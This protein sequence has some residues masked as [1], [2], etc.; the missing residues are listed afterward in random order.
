MGIQLFAPKRRAEYEVALRLRF[1]RNILFV[2]AGLSVIYL[3]QGWIG[4]IQPRLFPWDGLGILILASVCYL[5]CRSESPQRVS[6][7]ASWFVAGINILAAFESQFYGI[8]HPIS[9][10]YVLGILLAGL[11]IGGWF[12]GMWTVGGGLFVLL[13]GIVELIGANDV[14]ANPLNS[15]PALSQ[16]V[17][18]WWITFGLT[19]WLVSLFAYRLEE[20]LQLSRA[21]TNALKETVAA[22]NHEK[23]LEAFMRQALT[24]IAERLAVDYGTLFVHDEQDG[25]VSPQMVYQKGEVHSIS[26]FNSEVPLPV[27]APDLPIWHHLLETNTA[28]TIDNPAQDPRILNKE[29]LA[30]QGISTILYIPL[31]VGERLAGF[32][33]LN[34]L[35]KRRFAPAEIDLAVTL[36]QLVTLAMQLAQLA[37]QQE[38]AA[39][40]AERTRMSREL[41]DTLAQG[42]TG[43]LVQLEAAED[44]L[45]FEPEA[46]SSHLMR[47][48][49]LARSGLGEARRSV[50]GL[51]P[52]ILEQQGLPK[53]LENE[54]RKM[55]ADGDMTASYRVLGTPFPLS[56]EITGELLRIGQ[57]GITNA[58]RHSESDKIEVELHYEKEKIALKVIDHGLGFDPAINGAGFGLTSMRERA[59]EMGGTLHINSQPN[60]G[61]T[62]LCEVEV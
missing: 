32:F 56:P 43:I 2:F 7:A 10:I 51:R 28:L 18:F 17:L 37:E 35:E 4:L 13:W 21:Q 25:T 3:L 60:K 1:L 9:V 27:N 29:L 30:R 45:Q 33:G 42:L 59:V 14:V 11:L 15:W 5:V 6:L 46:V 38:N 39:I 31:F 55:T 54:L 34:L 19:G 24:T 23:E 36:A 8:Q 44:A 58:V 48:R 47:A 49:T 57:E 52:E 16:T 22:L 62:I 12:L 50:Y 61:T 20:L 41:H 26:T 53:A 40:D